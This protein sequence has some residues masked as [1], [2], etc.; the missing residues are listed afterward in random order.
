MEKIKEIFRKLEPK[1]KEKKKIRKLQVLPRT[2]NIQLIG[3]PERKK[4]KLKDVSM[5]RYVCYQT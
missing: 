2:P 3:V 4:N 1:G 5:G